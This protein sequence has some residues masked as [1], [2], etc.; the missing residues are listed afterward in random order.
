MQFKYLYTRLNVKSVAVSKKFYEDVLAL[1]TVFEDKSDDYVEL[2]AGPIRLSLFSRAKMRE[3]IPDENELK[4]EAHSAQV[5][6]TFKV[7]DLQ[8]SISYLKSKNVELLASP[9][10][11][12]DRG[13]ASCSFRDPDG[14]I[15]EIEEMS[16]I[17]I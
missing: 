6:L 12:S 1:E 8:K 16:D 3:F 14:N 2:D 11:Y 17:A 9:T 4:Y 15:I 10:T 7:S 13:F 5:V